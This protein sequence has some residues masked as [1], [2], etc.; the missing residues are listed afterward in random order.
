MRGELERVHCLIA[1]SFKLVVPPLRMNSAV[2]NGLE[3]FDSSAE[4]LQEES[5]REPEDRREKRG[6]VVEADE[7][8]TME[9]FSRERWPRSIEQN[10]WLEGG[11]VARLMV[12]LG[13]DVVSVIFKA[14]VHCVSLN[15]VERKVKV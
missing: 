13:D 5:E 7:L 15:E 3:G 4:I 12:W 9:N 2:A 1:V 10:G 11:L 14:I 6:E 8:W